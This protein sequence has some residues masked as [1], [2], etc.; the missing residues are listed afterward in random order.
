LPRRLRGL[1]DVITIHPPYVGRREVRTLPVEIRGFEPA[2]SLTDDSPSGLG[3]IE[4]ATH[5]AIG[6]LE[7]GGWMLVEVSS[8]RSR[9]V[10]SLLHRAGFGV[11]R[12]TRGD[13]PVSR[14]VAARFGR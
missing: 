9:A 4:R 3:L 12:S 13:V 11:V 1:V 2:E 10:K 8:D 7:P 14:V 5:E 6:W